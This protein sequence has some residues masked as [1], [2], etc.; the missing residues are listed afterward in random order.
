M[1][2]VSPTSPDDEKKARMS[3]LEKMRRGGFWFRKWSL[4]DMITLCWMVGIH[5]LAASALFV[6][7]WGAF[8]VATGLAFWTGIGSTISILKQIETL[9]R[10][11]KVFGLVIWAGCATTTTLLQRFLHSTYF[12]H[13]SALAVLLYHYGGF[14]YLA[15]GLGVR[16]VV[17]CQIAFVVQSVGH[18][19]GERTWNTRDTS[20]NNRWTG[21]FA[22]GEGWHNN[23]HAFPN[24]A[25]H[26]L[27]WWQFD[28]T[29]ELIKILELVGLATDVKLP[30]EAE[31]K[32]MKTLLRAPTKLAN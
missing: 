8:I 10:Q 6:F 11:M 1:S 18:I 17:V 15:W 27:E 30:T 26:G 22:L 25:R 21:M 28:L 13:P 4:V 5:V 19:W 16:I 3:E 23:H 20:T 12:W 2:L 32:R 7:D 24:S 14:P 29:W 9:I 31:K